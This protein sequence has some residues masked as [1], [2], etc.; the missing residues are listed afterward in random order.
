MRKKLKIMTILAIAIISFLNFNFESNQNTKKSTFIFKNSEALAVIA[1]QPKACW[2]EI[3]S[4]GEGNLTHQTFCTDC[5]AHLCRIWK[6]EDFCG[7][8]VSY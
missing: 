1:E 6:N 3:S 8:S 2:K 7:V 4:M 5:T